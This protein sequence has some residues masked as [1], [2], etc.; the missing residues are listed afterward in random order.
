M[1]KMKDKEVKATIYENAI[2]MRG[3]NRRVTISKHENYF[4]LYFEK[5]LSIEEIISAGKNNRSIST[6][7]CDVK[8]G[9]S[10]TCVHL[11]IESMDYLAEAY[12]LYITK[13]HKKKK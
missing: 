4:T 8:R 6:C 12:Q 1:K 2:S 5:I 7:H 9:K 11:T 10:I 13:I 3:Y